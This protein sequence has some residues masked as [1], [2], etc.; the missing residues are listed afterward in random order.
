MNIDNYQN[1]TAET[2]QSELNSKER[3]INWVMG[4]SGES[5]EVADYMKKVLFHDHPMN[6]EKLKDELG[7]ILWYISRL[8][9]EYEIKFSDIISYNIDKLNKRYPEGFDKERSINRPD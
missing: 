6:R 4:I 3:V 1:L 9:S 2:A 7:D 8:A 5:G